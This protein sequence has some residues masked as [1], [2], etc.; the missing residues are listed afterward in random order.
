M[1]NNLEILHL[2][3]ALAMSAW[4]PQKFGQKHLAHTYFEVPKAPLVITLSFFAYF[5]QVSTYVC[6]FTWGPSNPKVRIMLTK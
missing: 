4:Y 6:S 2:R 3:L 1:A 5:D